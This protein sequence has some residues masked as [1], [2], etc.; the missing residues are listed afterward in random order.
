MTHISNVNNGDCG[1]SRIKFFLNFF[2]LPSRSCTVLHA[3]LYHVFIVLAVIMNAAF[4]MGQFKVS[5]CAV[6]LRY[7][8]P[9]HS[10]AI[11]GIVITAFLA[12]V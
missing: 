2:T 1:S 9:M 3:M 8:G 5:M 6:Q 11:P 7:R 10:V 4:L 12:I